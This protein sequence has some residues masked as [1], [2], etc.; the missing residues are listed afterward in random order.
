[1]GKFNLSD[2]ESEIMKMLWNANKKMTLREILDYF[3]NEKEKNWQEQTLRKMMVRL[4]GKGVISS[5]K[6][7][8]IL[9]YY[10]AVTENENVQSWLKGLLNDLFEGSLKNLMIGFSGGSKLRKE[11]IEELREFIDE[12]IEEE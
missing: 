8:G 9:V 7:D 11:D 3:N 1:M 6:E 5:E 10:P 2:T 4:I 12:D